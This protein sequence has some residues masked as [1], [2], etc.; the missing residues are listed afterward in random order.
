MQADENQAAI[1]TGPA[2]LT[3]SRQ[4]TD[5]GSRRGA[6]SSSCIPTCFQ[7]ALVLPS[8]RATST[9]TRVPVRVVINAVGTCGAFAAWTR[10]EEA[11]VRRRRIARPRRR[12]AGSTPSAR[13]RTSMGGGGAREARSEVRTWKAAAMQATGFSEDGRVATRQRWVGCVRSWWKN[14]GRKAGKEGANSVWRGAFVSLAEICGGPNLR[15][16]P[17]RF[18]CLLR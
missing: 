1:R 13:T 17:G 12:Y 18:G 3:T 9:Q 16:V 14:V 15:A 4:P 11:A 6:S 8:A 2:T 7:N 10:S 5:H